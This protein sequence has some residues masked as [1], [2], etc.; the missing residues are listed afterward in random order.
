MA[1]VSIHPLEIRVGAL[2]SIALL[3]GAGYQQLLEFGRRDL[4]IKFGS[5][6]LVSVAH[7]IGT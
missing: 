3:I 2:F 5:A 7:C 1:Y 6:Y 4:W